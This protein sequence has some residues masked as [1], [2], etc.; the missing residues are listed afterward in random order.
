MAYEHRSGLPRAYSRV[1]AFPSW[2]SVLFRE[3]QYSQ[4]AEMVE[5][6]EILHNKLRAIGNLVARDGDRLEGCDILIDSDAETVT[7]T[8]GRIYVEGRSL[9][10]GAATLAD[11]PMTGSV[12]IGVRLTESWITEDDEPALYG[13]EPG[14]EA[15]GENGAARGIV[16]LSW[17]FS[18]DETEGNLYAVYLLKDGVA[19]DQTPPP[20][21]TGINAQLAVYDFDANGNYVV[22]GCRVTALG[23]DGADQV[24]SIEAGV[25]N[26][27]GFK[28][29]RQAA[30]RHRQPEAS[31]QLRIPTEVHTF[32]ANPTTIT[33]NHTPI[34]T[35]R[36]VLLEKEVTETV[37]RGG[38]PA[39]MDNLANTG[40]TAIVEVK[41]GG[42]TYAPTADYL[43]SG[44]KV[45][46]S[47][48]GAEPSTGSTYTVKYRYLGIVIPSAQTAT[49][50]TVAGGVN[51]GQI[52]VDYD[53]H[54]PR[55][56]I[57][58]LDANG[59]PVYIKGI[60]NRANP[61]PPL[62]PANVL[63]L[64]MIE[65]NWGGKP[66]VTNV[67]VPAM[68]MED[69]YRLKL[70]LIDALDLIALERL[71]RD[72]D[73]REPTAKN[74]VF[75]DPF[76]SDRY[77]DQGEPQTAA[78]FDGLVRLAIDPTFKPFSLP[79]VVLLDWTEAVAI[80]QPLATRC[81]KI[82]PYQAF[83]PM[84]AQ[85]TL[86]PAVDYW[87]ET[88]TEWTS[89]STQEIA[90]P[91]QVRTSGSSGRTTT[92]TTR[93]TAETTIVDNREELLDLLRQISV[94]YKIKGFGAGEIL[95]SLTFDGIDITP[96]GPAKVANGSGE[97][98]GT[99]VIPANVPAG[100]KAVLA[101]GAGGS[102]SAA[103]FIGQGTIDITVMR[104]VITTTV[105]TQTAITTGGFGSGQS[106]RDPLAQTF[107]LVEG[108]HV[109]GINLQICAIGD[110]D[111]AIVLE[112]VEVENGIPTTNVVAQAFYD[113]HTAV[114]G[115]WTEI[116][117]AYPVW[118]DGG[119]E[120]AFVVKTDDADHAI[121]TAALG[122]FDAVR[123]QKV[124]AQPYS[125]GVMLSSANARTWTPHQDED[126][127][128]QIVEAVFAPATKTIDIG[129]F[130]AVDMSDLLV[131]AEVD[132]PTS[133]AS[134][135]F[136]VE[137]SDGSV[138]LLRPGQA[139]ER[140]DYYSGLVK[141]RA[142]LSGSV[143]V[144]PVLFPLVLAIAGKVR[145]GGTYV[146]RAFDMGT[147]IDLIAWLKTYIPTGSSITVEADAADG[148]WQ[149]VAQASQAPLQDPGWI[150]RRYTRDDHNA[151]PVG[152]LRLTLAGTPAARPM[153]YDFRAISAP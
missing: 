144:S 150:E 67:G 38:T 75:V 36:E 126:I 106:G 111:N 19:I 62:V 151:N 42:T 34:A 74:G 137:L 24:F 46:W 88:A 5:A 35:I 61:L 39:G 9:A 128:F 102:E 125:V 68:T 90:V 113:M 103:L 132:L 73:S 153:G 64:G 78:V 98:T 112:V 56:D 50:L 79:G 87:T 15:E 96:A 37:T 25:A 4:A 129:T 139:W 43:K 141:L 10:I 63:A 148:N 11:V 65:N 40:V 55:T 138:T 17:G 51:G 21:L 32:G 12:Q 115:G 110:R 53:F 18:G 66:T 85:M 131:R 45:D 54:L 30:L 70:R 31:D 13:L 136:E 71:Q 120:F 99:F 84:P 147:A 118:L 107:I 52:Q 117:F 92:T 44:D 121:S 82:N 83:D 57:L 127:T 41:Q 94:A 142:V 104:R 20:D 140:Q 101:K 26:I 1:P 133:A 3:R 105:T 97:I 91:V 149:A 123:Q 124:A 100:S 8:A 6:Q 86:D 145:A 130:N 152:R 7:L 122:D 135:H 119:V 16:S 108:R 49:T 146:T 58:G 76:T 114:V 22:S 2:D 33:L 143:H 69:N 89:D 47:P 27:A 77:R 48:A 95:Q 59:L 134:F 72:I 81:S 60:S 28:R 14:S 93:Q 23:K 29:T 80:E 109:A 116:R